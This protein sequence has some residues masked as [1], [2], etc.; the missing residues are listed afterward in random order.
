[1]RSPLLGPSP[2]A[3]HGSLGAL[4]I[5]RRVIQLFVM[6]L[7]RWEVVSAGNAIPSQSQ[8]C[9]ASCEGCGETRPRHAASHGVASESR[10]PTAG[11][12]ASSLAPERPGSF[13][14]AILEALLHPDFSF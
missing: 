11:F 8:G 6:N 12:S 13:G 10:C 14:L 2:G 3:G 7:I 4:L 9:L 5:F 1:M